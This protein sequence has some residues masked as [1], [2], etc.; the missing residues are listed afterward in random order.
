MALNADLLAKEMMRSIGGQTPRQRKAAF[1]RLARAI[2][3]HFQ[4][5]A[6]VVVTGVE[7]GS[8]SAAGRI[9]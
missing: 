6:L 9:Q 1:T 5:N 8:S 2:V 4:R 7:S 3:K